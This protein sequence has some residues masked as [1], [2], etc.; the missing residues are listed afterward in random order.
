MHT[1][2]RHWR[3]GVGMGAAFVIAS[4]STN[5]HAAPTTTNIALNK[6]TT[7]SSSYS[8]STRGDKAVDG[9]AGT[10]WRTK[11]RSTLFSEWI[12]LDL[13]N[14]TSVSRIVLKWNSAYA[15]RY[16]VE[17]SQD[18]TSWKT[19][20]ATSS[21]DGGTDTI[22]FAAT[23]ARYV[24]MTSF[25]WNNSQRIRLNELE[26]YA[27]DGVAPPPPVS[28]AW[29]VVPSP[30]APGSSLLRSVAAVDANTVW[31][32][33]QGAGADFIDRTLIQRWNGNAWTTMDS[34]NPSFNGDVLYGVSAVSAT[35]AW[36][37]GYS[38]SRNENFARAMTL[39]WD[40][41]FWHEA[42]APDV[43]GLP[44]KLAAVS[45]L[46]PTAAWAVGSTVAALPRSTLNIPL[47]SFWN[48]SD[49]SVVP[50]PALFD[51]AFGRLV[52]VTAIDA[53]NV[54]AVGE[55]F[56]GASTKPL[57]MRWNGTAWSVAA[58]PNSVATATLQAI[59]ASGVNDIWVVGNLGTGNLT[60]RYN[61]SSWSVIAS[62]NDLSRNDL[63]NTLR[64]VVAI[65]PSDAWAVG[66]AT[67]TR[68]NAA[69][70]PVSVE[71]TTIMHWDGKAWSM[72]PSPDPS[73]QHNFLYGVARVNSNDLWAVGNTADSNN[74]GRT[75]IQR[76][77]SP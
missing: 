38:N 65:N 3:T 5:I 7:V 26:V 76:Y 6:A 19:V 56:D 31:A 9:N 48:G 77:T 16:N 14:T 51:T 62:P 22:D 43:P 25:A 50:N 54:W 17:V 57:V 67:A 30:N 2:T 28:G 73:I 52:G 39:R 36:A 37:V 49:W 8:A 45:T 24:R 20:F 1:A 63:T 58:L 61:G 13:G 68:L 74:I 21:E 42:P 12:Q 40:G 69:G 27:D 60:L 59:G 11:V 44:E 34:P 15:T 46:S 72:V 47:I 18:T 66:T 53:N 10:F 70:S 75:M 23:S 33:G 41:S 71:F 29:S 4:L 32:V 64:S 55:V 35:D